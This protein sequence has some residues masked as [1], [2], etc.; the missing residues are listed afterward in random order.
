MTTKIDKTFKER[1]EDSINRLF[2][3][4]QRNNWAGYDP[5]DALN[6]RLFK[7]LPFLDSMLLR[8]IL[9]QFLK[10][11][12]VNL[13]KLLLISKTQNP[14]GL[15]IFLKAFLKMEKTGIL[16]DKAL[17]PFMVQRIKELRSPSNLYC[18]GYSFPWQGRSVLAPRGEANLVCTVFVIDALIDVYE[19]NH[20]SDCL[21]MATSAAEYLNTL[22]WEDKHGDVGFSYP[23]PGIQTRVHNAN[24]L[25]AAMLSRVYKQTGDIKYLEHAL[26]AARYSVRKQL[27]DGSWYYGENKKSHWID[28]FHTGYNLEA[29]Q[30]INK[31]LNTNEFEINIQKGFEFY[32]NNFFTHDYLPKYFHNRLYP[33]DIHAVAQ[34][35]ITLTEFK[36]Y[37]KQAEGIAEKVCFW[38]IENMQSKEGFFYYQKK[39]YYTNKIPYMRWSQAWMFYA[40][41][42][43]LAS[44]K[45]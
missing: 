4:C 7:Q 40:M 9:T 26:K 23:V 15:A 24:F 19:Y 25:A 1:L 5:Y 17:I 27:G 45:S 43:L 44:I 31:N 21:L 10:R 6:S 2:S 22:F 12:P 8:L 18:W 37:N 16:K 20:N 28:N 35:I 29:L 42:I 34:S 39:K 41:A 11:C 33:I 3:Y 36:D 13:R 38:A 14:K 30:V 32:I